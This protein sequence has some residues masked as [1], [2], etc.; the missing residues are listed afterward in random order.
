L[1]FAVTTIAMAIIAA[2]TVAIATI[3]WATV[4]MATMAATATTM[5]Q[6]KE[7]YKK[8]IVQVK[9]DIKAFNRRNAMSATNQDASLTSIP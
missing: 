3:A 1:V 8:T 9:G 2:A 5:A 4:A 6:T 7:A